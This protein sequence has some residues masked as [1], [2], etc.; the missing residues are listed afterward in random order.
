[1]TSIFNEGGVR[2]NGVPKQSDKG[3]LVSVITV[4]FNDVS[5][6]E[7]TIQSVLAQTYVN[8]EYIIVDGGSTD[9]T[10]D[11]IN[12]YRD[13]IDFLISE[14]D[15]GI[16][17]AMNKGISVATGNWINFMNA[18]D[19]FIPDIFTEICHSLDNR[20]PLCKFLVRVEHGDI[21]KE[22]ASPKYLSR[23]MLNHQG[24]FYRFDCIK[25]QQF[26]SDLKIIGDLKHLVEYNLWKKASYIDLLIAEYKGGGVASTAKSRLTNYRERMSVLSWKGVS[27]N[28]RSYIFLTAVIGYIYNILRR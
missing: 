4:V 11:V 9:G 21:R 28:V 24:I 26:D 13:C 20:F 16:Y 27:I 1:M 2:C 25:H 10:L 15:V 7:A 22:R 5:N 3:A 17:D 14:S 6:I 18:G 8:V 12:K 19:T 23:H